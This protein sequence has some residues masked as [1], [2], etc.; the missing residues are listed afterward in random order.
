MPIAHQSALAGVLHAGR[1]VPERL[2]VVA[3]QTSVA[4]INVMRPLGEDLAQP[5]QKDPRGICICQDPV[6]R[7]AY[8]AKWQ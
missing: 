8:E 3:E 5:R 2:G 7:A 6:Y 1:L 4:R